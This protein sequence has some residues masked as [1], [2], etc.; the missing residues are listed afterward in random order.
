MDGS[1]A[2]IVAP[3]LEVQHALADLLASS[4]LVP[5]LASSVSEA[6]TVLRNSRPAVILSSEELPDGGFCDILRLSR[7]DAS[8]V[9]VIVFSRLADWDAYLHIVRAGAFDY[10]RYP[11]AHGEI[12]RVVWNALSYVSRG[13]KSFVSAA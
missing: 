5:I 1:N 7:A 3:D 6:E 8:R 11:P 13:L 12:E 4:S 9:P 10:V 2:L